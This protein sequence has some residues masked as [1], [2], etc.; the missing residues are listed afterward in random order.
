[1][2]LYGVSKIHAFLEWRPRLVHR[3]DTHGMIPIVAIIFYDLETF[4]TH[5]GRDRIA[6]FAGILTDEH[7]D[8]QEHPYELRCLPP[9]D[10]LASP[11]ACLT[12]GITPQAALQTGLLEP[13]FA[14]RIHR[15]FTSHERTLI[16]GYNNAKFDDEFVRHLFYRTFLDPYG[17]HYQNGNRRMDLFSLIP[18]IFDFF[19][20][21]FVWPRN[22]NG[23]PDFR[24]E[25][26]ATANDALGGTSHEALADT[27]ALRNIAKRISETIPDVWESVPILLDKKAIVGRIRNAYINGPIAGSATGRWAGTYD[28]GSITRAIVTFSSALL[29]NENRSSTFLL[30]LG[31]EGGG[32][33]AET[34]W[35][36]DLQTE[37]SSLLQRHPEEIADEFYQRDRPSEVRSLQRINP[38]R[39]P[40]I[41]SANQRHVTALE[42]KGVPLSMVAEHIRTAISLDAGRWVR[43]FL[44]HVNSRNA[45]AG[46]RRVSRDVDEELYDGF[47]NDTDRSAVAPL[48]DASTREIASILRSF[49][50]VDTRYRLLVDRFVGRYAPQRLSLAERDRFRQE[51]LDRVDI[52]AFDAEWN[53]AKEAWESESLRSGLTRKRQKDV[54]EQLRDHRNSVVARLS[55]HKRWGT[56]QRDGSIAVDE[57]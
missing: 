55:G 22:D 16:L 4:G 12:T 56:L 36:L 10:Y 24:L 2:T 9:P 21:T 31:E 28:D 51:A 27:F 54:L 26:L 49:N 29:K 20:D 7:L 34:W 40:F 11:G 44:D 14:R 32:T 13:D 46:S 41:L 30:P 1:M 3:N 15:W 52:D 37:P 33:G 6:E 43:R 38:R 50:F 23:T 45:D 48:I 5:P 47:L 57:S 8:L 25:A 19:P 53:A 39:F 35:F 42:N 18:A 17:W